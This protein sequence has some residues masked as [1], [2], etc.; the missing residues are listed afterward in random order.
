MSLKQKKIKFKPKI[1]LKHNIYAIHCPQVILFDICKT[2][3][4]LLR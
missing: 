4:R 2:Y 1:K 3:P